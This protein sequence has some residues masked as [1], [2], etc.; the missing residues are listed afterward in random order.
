MGCEFSNIL[1]LLHNFFNNSRHKLFNFNT[2]GSFLW[3]KIDK[4]NHFPSIVTII[5][6]FTTI[7]CLLRYVILLLF[8]FPHNV[9]NVY[10][11][12][13]DKI[14]TNIPVLNQF[15]DTYVPF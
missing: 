15:H 1:I 8:D 11:R 5:V 7:A 14:E 12:I 3:R 9:R 6:I 10:A 13:G 2:Q 4:K